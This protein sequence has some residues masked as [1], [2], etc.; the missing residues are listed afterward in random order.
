MREG[1]LPHTQTSAE[2]TAKV[3]ATPHQEFFIVSDQ[4]TRRCVDTSHLGQDV[5]RLLPP[6]H[7]DASVGPHE[8]EPRR[9]GPAAHA[10]VARTVAAA[11]DAGYL[12]HLRARN[13]CHELRAV[14]G[15]PLVLVTLPDLGDG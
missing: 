4:R 2:H 3:E 9:V 10:V 11:D 15:D 7:R 6:H 5:C 12:R 8:Q 13:G 1:T 14:F